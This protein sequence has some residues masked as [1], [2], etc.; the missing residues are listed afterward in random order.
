MQVYVKARSKRDLNTRISMWG[1]HMDAME[2]GV[3]GVTYRQ[4]DE[5]PTGTVVKIFSKRA[6]ESPIATAYGTWDAIKR[7]VK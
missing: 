1:A 2:Y 4:L 5:C 3:D 6:G 7:K